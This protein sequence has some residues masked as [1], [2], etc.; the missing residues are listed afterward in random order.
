MPPLMR[1]V[2]KD[3]DELVNT[4]LRLVQLNL[5]PRLRVNRQGLSGILPRPEA[6]D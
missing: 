2:L 6:Q 4:L 5:Y 1:M 3:R